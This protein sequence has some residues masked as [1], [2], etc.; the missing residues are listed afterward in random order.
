M[1][2]EFHVD[3]LD[4]IYTSLLQFCGGCLRAICTAGTHHMCACEQRWERGGEGMAKTHPSRMEVRNVSSSKSGRAGR[5]N[6]SEPKAVWLVVGG[7]VKMVG[8]GPPDALFVPSISCT[9]KS[10]GEPWIS[11]A[12]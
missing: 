11:P 9:P 3:K 6:E 10:S 5:Y 1:P 7:S 12:L 4:T 8:M 2:V